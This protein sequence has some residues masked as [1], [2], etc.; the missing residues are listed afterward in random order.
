M[1][2]SGEEYNLTSKA[3]FYVDKKSILKLDNV[4]NRKFESLSKN[5]V[6]L[7]PSDYTYWWRLDLSS[8]SGKAYFLAINSPILDQVNLHYFDG[9]QW[10]VKKNGDF[11]Q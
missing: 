9:D 3:E 7:K 8:F 4:L 10:S 1:N 11:I 2:K 6:G 5:A